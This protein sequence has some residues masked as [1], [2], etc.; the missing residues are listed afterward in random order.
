[1][2]EEVIVSTAL[3]KEHEIKA[4]GTSDILS[5][6][7]FKAQCAA[8]NLQPGQLKGKEAIDAVLSEEMGLTTDALKQIQKVCE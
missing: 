8:D 2:A 6:A 7:D 3:H 4:P 1:M 5:V